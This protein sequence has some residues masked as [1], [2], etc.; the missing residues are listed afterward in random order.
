MI[1]AKG[2][3]GNTPLT[4]KELLQKEYNKELKRI[5][6][7]IR[8]A[9]KRGYIFEENAIPQKPQ[10][11]TSSSV[12]KL[13]KI[14][15]TTLYEKAKF[16]DTKQ[17]K[18][19]KGTEAR[20]QERRTS[21]L[22]AAQTRAKQ[23][24]EKLEK[25]RNKFYTDKNKKGKIEKKDTSQ[26]YATLEGVREQI[27]QWTPSSIWNNRL[28]DVKQRDKNTLENILNGAIAQQGEEAV[29]KRLEENSLEVNTLLQEILYGSGTTEGNFKNGRTQVNF[30]LARF[31]AIVMGRSLTVEESMDLT[32]L[33]ETLEVNN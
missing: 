23:K 12:N 26:K 9:T 1:T 17:G 13:K 29:G 11:I 4:H 6:Q 15:P 14:T 24:L 3:T 27:R 21:A 20:K 32:E 7:F 8:R 28:S 22:K 30:D 33:A 31:S 5:K 2:V 19:I 16:V 25:V 18:T 10:R